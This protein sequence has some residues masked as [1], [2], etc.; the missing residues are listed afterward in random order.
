MNFTAKRMITVIAAFLVLVSGL[1]LITRLTAN[2]DP[3]DRSELLGEP[4]TKVNDNLHQIDGPPPA[5]DEARAY[6]LYRSGSPSRQ[7]FAK[8]CSV[9]GVERV[10]VMD[11]G[12]QSHERRYQAE[13]ICPN[14]QVVYNVN[15]G[16]S[17]VS[18]GFLKWFDGQVESAKKDEAGVLFRCK[19]GSHRTGRLASYYQIK[20]QGL[21]LADALAVLEHKG[22]M[23]EFWSLI[24]VPQV[25]A[26]DEH[27]KGQPCTQPGSC[28]IN[29]SNLWAP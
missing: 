18:D 23:M 8:W 20:H 1:F 25:I 9:Y 2:A 13:G 27:L 10:I 12:A 24:F 26:I 4:Y 11:G 17:P 28:V 7:T 29:N 14:I 21:S 19:T 22:K 15:Q 16:L 5:P 6:R 3:V